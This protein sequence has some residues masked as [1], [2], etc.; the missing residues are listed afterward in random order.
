MRIF[1]ERNV[2]KQL[3]RQFHRRDTNSIYYWVLNCFFFLFLFRNQCV[4]LNCSP[5]TKTSHHNQFIC[6]LLT[7]TGD[8]LF[9]YRS[10]S[11]WTRAM[12]DIELCACQCVP[13]IFSLSNRVFFLFELPLN[14]THEKK[15]ERERE[16][17]LHASHGFHCAYL[18]KI[19]IYLVLKIK[20]ETKQLIS[21]NLYSQ[22][23]FL[24]VYG[25]RANTL[26]ESGWIRF[27]CRM[28]CRIWFSSN[29][30]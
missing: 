16:V 17:R 21:S 7:T 26:N 1:G 28:K 11:T 4:H 3:T 30:S 29:R 13:I 6:P 24:L 10:F 2:N 12:N 27:V 19:P 9:L 5:T 18:I 8:N 23:C 15:R 25:L 14:D 22:T 20:H